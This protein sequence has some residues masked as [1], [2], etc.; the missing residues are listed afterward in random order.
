[1]AKGSPTESIDHDQRWTSSAW[2]SRLRRR[3]LDW[4]R[5]NQRPLPW[6]LTRDPYRIWV[7]EIMLQ[8]TQVAT[9][10]P[11]Y[12][13]FLE[14]F[15]TV[16]SL[17][18]ADTDQ[19]LRYWEGLGYY[20][21]GR[22]LH[23]AAQRIV[24]QHRG[25]FPLDYDDVLN[26]PGIG[27]Y[28]AGAILS[29]STGQRLPVVEANTVRLYSRLIALRRPPAESAS[30][31]LLWNVAESLLPRRDCGQ[32]NQAA[33]ELGALICTPR[34]PDC[35]SCPLVSLCAAREADLQTEIPGRVKKMIYEDRRH[36]AI[37]A[38]RGGKYLLRQCGEGQHWAGLWDFPR[39]DATQDPG[40]PLQFAAESFQT[41]FGWSIQFDHSITTLRHAVTRF[42]I[43]MTAYRVTAVDPGKVPADQDNQGWFTPQQ[44]TQ[45]PLNTTGRKLA[46]L[47][48]DG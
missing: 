39:Y 5:G 40:D 15:P 12:E 27:R 16:D 9:V 45:M 26:L 11:F 29:I 48:V 17:A 18:S 7:S 25:V 36:V 32:F 33:M 47:L 22:Q 20:R 38:E 14:R 10:I 31:R 41:E 1:V 42:R 37:V 19:V 4:F 28:T 46:R 13:R 23:A 3:L 2:R 30:N 24:E 8:Q 44:M 43:T 35:P 21:R 6:R 34:A